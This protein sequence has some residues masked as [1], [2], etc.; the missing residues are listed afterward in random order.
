MSDPSDATHDRL[1]QEL[2]RV[3]EQRRRLA[4]Q[5]GGEDPD[6]PDFGV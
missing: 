2:A 6:D 5:L 1:E 3:R 4:V